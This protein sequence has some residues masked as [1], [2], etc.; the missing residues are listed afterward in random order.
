M[1][2]EHAA[3]STESSCS[4][5]SSAPGSS[6]SSSETAHEVA[7]LEAGVTSEEAEERRDEW[8][9]E[10]D[11]TEEADDGGGGGWFLRASSTRRCR[12]LE[13]PTSTLSKLS[14][15][16]E[17]RL[18]TRDCSLCHMDTGLQPLPHGVA[19]SVI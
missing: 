7:V 5:P 13:E 15:D 11:E 16:H 12:S 17:S 1:N 3:W 4:G 8:F 6:S 10:I 9:D 18:D 2:L 14:V 19:A